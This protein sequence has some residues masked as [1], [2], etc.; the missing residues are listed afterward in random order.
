MY[1]TNSEIETAMSI[2]STLFNNNFKYAITTHPSDFN[3]ECYVSGLNNWELENQNVLSQNSIRLYNGATKVCLCC[4]E[5]KNWVIKIGLDLSSPYNFDNT[6]YCELEALNFS[7][8]VDAGLDKFFASTYKIGVIED[9]PVF[10]QEGLSIDEC[11]I[12]DSFYKYL[13]NSGDFDDY[14]DEEAR[15]DAISDCVCE[16][17]DEERL[18]ALF[19]DVELVEF[20]QKNKINDLHSANYGYDQNGEIVICDFSGF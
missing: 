11:S 14:E 15:E 5:L 1:P 17:E 2:C 20:C 6:N 16:L 9:V 12:E 7:K 10:L 8:A 18:Y 19:D 4:S 13:E 3:K